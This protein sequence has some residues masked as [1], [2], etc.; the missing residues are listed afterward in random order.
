MVGGGVSDGVV[1][2]LALVSWVG[3]YIHCV[4][5]LYSSLPPV[6]PRD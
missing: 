2:P 6:R 1:V 4:H 5:D 3:R